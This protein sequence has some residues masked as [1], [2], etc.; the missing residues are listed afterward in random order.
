MVLRSWDADPVGVLNPWPE[1]FPSGTIASWPSALF[2]Y[3]R[4][5]Y[6]VGLFRKVL[7]LWDA[8]PVGVLNPWP[9]TFPSGT[10]ASWLSALF[11]RTRRLRRGDVAQL[12]ERLVRNEEVDGS[13]PFIST[14][15]A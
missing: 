6:D 1:T 9:E 4:G 12:G 2:F 8:D 7:R 14:T 10:I 15:C 11:F 3:E 13:I 5:A